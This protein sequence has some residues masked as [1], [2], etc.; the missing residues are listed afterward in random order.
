VWREFFETAERLVRNSEVSQAPES[1]PREPM[2][3]NC[4]TIGQDFT[5]SAVGPDACNN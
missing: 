3:E 5:A 2:L 1:A 4:A